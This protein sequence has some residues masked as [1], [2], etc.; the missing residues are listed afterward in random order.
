M[1]SVLGTKKKYGTLEFD[2]VRVMLERLWNDKVTKRKEFHAFEHLLIWP[3]LLSFLYALY[4]AF[5][6]FQMMAGCRLT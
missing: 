5:F 2:V 6:F 3:H 1:S 4:C